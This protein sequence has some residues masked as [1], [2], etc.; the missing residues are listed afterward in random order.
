MNLERHF[1]R[2]ENLRELFRLARHFEFRVVSRWVTFGLLVG[3]ATGALAAA[4]YLAADWVRH[5]V[6]AWGV[7]LHSPTPKGEPSLFAGEHASG[8]LR[9]WLLIIAPAIGAAGCGLLIHYVCPQARG[10]T[11]GYI[12]AFHQQQPRMP[13]RLP[14]LKLA[15]SSIFL[16]FG[17]SAGREGPIAHIGSAIGGWFGR[18]FR[19]NDR[20]RRLLLV[21]GAAGGI[22]AIFR[23]PLGGALF[24]VEVLY[25]D[26]F[27]AEAL[28]PA[29]LSAVVAYST[30][31]FVF[32]EGAM[33]AVAAE[34]PFDPRQLPLYLLMAMGCAVVGVLFVWLFDEASALFSKLRIS[35]PLRAAAGGLCVGLLAVGLPLLAYGVGLTDSHEELLGAPVLGAGYGWLQEVLLPTGRLPMGGAGIALLLLFAIGKVLATSLSNGSGGAGGV[36]GP[37]VVIGGMVGG[38]FGLAFHGWFP[39]VVPEP[40]A[41]AIVGMACFVGGVT[42]SPISTLVM[43]SEMTG[44]YELLV[45][46]MMAEAVTVALMHRWTHYKAQVASRR[47]SPAHVEDYALAALERLTVEDAAD[48]GAEVHCVPANM[49]IPQLLRRAAELDS[50][51]VCVEGVDDRPAGIISLDSLRSAYF[52]EDA[53]VVAVAIDCASPFATVAPSDTLSKALETLTQS[54]LPQLPVLSPDTPNRF[55]GL[56][57]FQN[58]LDAY[59]RE[60]HRT[61]STPPASAEYG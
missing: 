26:D 36:F 2:L 4:L 20:D 42:H 1:A 11:E 25:R 59:S 41:F 40:T 7:G 17:A 34:F 51:I 24:A 48:I 12:E 47:H 32:G 13:R 52:D 46:I 44:N 8:D 60:L 55:V 30:F 9:Y 6:F 50:A 15:A 53:A 29:V 23:T 54:R 19:L 18:V 43:A 22:G 21:A 57:H 14:W 39:E 49:S 45:P 61:P 35:P 28:V 38:A 16:G 27:E 3:L 33:F 56:L 10:G 58:I 5:V 37:S 31:T